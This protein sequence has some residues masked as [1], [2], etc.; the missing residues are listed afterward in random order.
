MTQFLRHFTGRHDELSRLRELTNR[1]TGTLALVYGPRGA[2]KTHLVAQLAT[3]RRRLY[4]RAAETTPALNRLELYERLETS[5]VDGGRPREAPDWPVLV[6]ALAE[7]EHPEESPVVVVDDAQHLFAGDPE[8]FDALIREWERLGRQTELTFVLSATGHSPEACLGTE[9]AEEN[10]LDACIELALLDYRDAGRLVPERPPAQKAYIYGVFGG[11]PAYL[12]AIDRNE[13]FGEAVARTMLSPR[14]PVYSR[15][16]TLLARMPDIRRPGTYRAVMTAVAGGARETHEVARRAG[17]GDRPTVARRALET[18]EARG[19]IRRR[20]NMGAGKRAAWKSRITDPAVRFWSHFAHRHRHQLAVGQPA[21]VWRDA[22]TPRLDEFMKVAFEQ[23]A[24]QAFARFHEQWGLPAPARWQRWRGTD[25]N[26][27]PI[28]IDIACELTDGRCL[29]GQVVWSSEP[30]DV[31]LHFHLER[32][33]ETLAGL[34]EDWADAALDPDR[35][36]GHLY[37]SA[38][39]FT[40]H[41][42]DRADTSPRLH[43]KSLE[44]LYPEGG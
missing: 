19:L 22:V 39:G 16:D 13:A 31:D 36:R 29:T 34:G 5:E 17:L 10:P 23:I 4:F 32:D 20:R 30:V 35:S 6:R 3:D 1:P 41:F 12:S 21:D 15:V 24:E 2:G 42:R 44:D 18:L 37:V 40:D 28:T 25:R 11:R 8:E 26:D 33:L 38:G 27:R 9:L 43:L 7:R 14:G